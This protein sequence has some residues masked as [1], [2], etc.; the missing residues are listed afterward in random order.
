MGE[1]MQ[2]MTSVPSRKMKILI[3]ASFVVALAICAST[4]RAFD[5]AIFAVFAALNVVFLV[6]RCLW[7][8]EIKRD[9]ITISFPLWPRMNRTFTRPEIRQVEVVRNPIRLFS[10]ADYVRLRFAESRKLALVLMGTSNPQ[11]LIEFV[12][13]AA[14]S[15]DGRRTTR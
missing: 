4:G 9:Q 6:P 12:N 14:Q 2:N 8:F 7:G 11:P 13:A 15:E 10:Y 5:L 1:E 3:V